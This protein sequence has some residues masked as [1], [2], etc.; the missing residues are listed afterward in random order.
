MEAFKKHL[1]KFRQKEEL[2]KE[3]LRPT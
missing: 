3:G 1:L 2:G